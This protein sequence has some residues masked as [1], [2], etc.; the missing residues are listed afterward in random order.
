MTDELDEILDGVNKWDAKLEDYAIAKQAI[1]DLIAKE[2][3]KARID[4]LEKIK[5]KATSFTVA[6]SGDEWTFAVEIDK[7]GNRISELQ[8]LSNKEKGTE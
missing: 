6:V 1:L 5:N 2:C 7:I 3:T 8:G 4:E